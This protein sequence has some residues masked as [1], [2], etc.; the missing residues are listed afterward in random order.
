MYGLWHT[1]GAVY[2]WIRIHNS[3]FAGSWDWINIGFFGVCSLLLMLIG[4]VCFLPIVSFV[5][6]KYFLGGKG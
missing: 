1:S 5:V 2:Y 3:Y 4:G 6:G